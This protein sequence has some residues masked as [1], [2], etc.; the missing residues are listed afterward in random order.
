MV[1]TYIS[2]AIEKL[3][4]LVQAKPII[5]CKYTEIGYINVC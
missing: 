5:F 3:V 4:R 2:P 1:N